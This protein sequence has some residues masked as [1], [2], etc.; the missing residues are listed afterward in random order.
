MKECHL[1][2]ICSNSSQEQ[3]RHVPCNKISSAHLLALA[4]IFK[5]FKNCF[6]LFE[7]FRFEN[8]IKINLIHNQM[9]LCFVCTVRVD[10]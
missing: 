4:V 8:N 3:A 2:N 5:P 9:A 10:F 7:I 1:H 6:P